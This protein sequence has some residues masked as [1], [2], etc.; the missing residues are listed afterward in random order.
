MRSFTSAVFGLALFAT[1]ALALE[2]GQEFG[3]WT[4]QCV[5][6][7]ENNSEACHITQRLVVEGSGEQEKAVQMSVGFAP[8]ESTPVTIIRLPLGL[9]LLNGITLTVD[10]GRSQ[11]FPVQVCASAG[12]QTTLRLEPD[13]LE[14]LKAGRRLTITSYNLRQEAVQVPISLQG[15]AQAIEALQAN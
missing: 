3:Q 12:C 7:D 14:T 8:G 6:D 2:S 9:W 13:M 4:A 1:P 5:Q 11:Q 15:F 10:D